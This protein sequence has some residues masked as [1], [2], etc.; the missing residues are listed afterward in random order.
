VTASAAAAPESAPRLVARDLDVRAVI[1]APEQGL[2]DY[3]LEL[4]ASDENEA[5]LAPRR[6][7]WLRRRT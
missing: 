5:P 7:G 6:R 4:T 1:P 3:F 2:E